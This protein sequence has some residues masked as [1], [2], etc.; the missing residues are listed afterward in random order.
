LLE[1]EVLTLVA[2]V[3]IK[4]FFVISIGRSRKSLNLVTNHCVTPRET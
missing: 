2:T 3:P 1:V 4:A